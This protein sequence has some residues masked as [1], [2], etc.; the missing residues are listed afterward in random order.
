VQRNPGKWICY[1][2][3]TPMTIGGG[4]KGQERDDSKAM[5]VLSSSPSLSPPLHR[6]A[7][8]LTCLRSLPPHLSLSASLLFG[9][10][11]LCLLTRLP[12]SLTLTVLRPIALARTEH[13][14]RVFF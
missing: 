14:L 4:D 13:A 12:H 10:A 9:V 5:Q 11:P 2:L 3:D 8:L 1:E 6:L 7:S